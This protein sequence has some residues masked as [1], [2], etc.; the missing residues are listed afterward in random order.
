MN[1]SNRSETITLSNRAFTL[2][3]L[4]VV[5]AIIAILAGM[6][7]PALARAKDKAKSITCLNSMRQWGLAQR[8]YAD[9]NKGML[10]RDGMGENGLYPGNIT[11]G[12][13]TGHPLDPAAW[14]NA[15]P[16]YVS[17]RPLSNYWNSN[18]TSF[19]SNI[20]SLPF[21]GGQGKIFHC[22]AAQISP[23]DAPSGGGQNGF[24]SIVM[25][26]DL[27]NQTPTTRWRY[28]LGW[29]GD[30][31]WKPSATVLMLDAFFAPSEKSPRNS[32]N[33][34]NPAA[35]W[36]QFAGRHNGGDGG[37][38]A[39]VDGHAEYW[40]QYSVTNGTFSGSVTATNE[41]W[42]KDLVWNPINRAMKDK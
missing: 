29:I 15:L 1:T 16:R 26:I 33:S 42:N 39:F 21:P 24:F 27:K 40:R 13:Q 31:L 41:P 11:N 35:R 19:A 36:V 37:N 4:L 8:M 7:L 22:P 23:S 14:F 10:C 3:E 2:I 32:F 9:D 17:E 25:N 18:S 5:I 28:P 20:V 38:I 12:I 6:L 34:V 30:Q